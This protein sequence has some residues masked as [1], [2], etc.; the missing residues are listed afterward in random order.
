MKLDIK[1][2]TDFVP[3]KLEI[4]FESWFEIHDFI[5]RL[6]H[7]NHLPNPSSPVI[8]KVENFIANLKI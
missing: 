1:R 7:D 5:E 2:Q 8:S 4:T 3:I 6:K